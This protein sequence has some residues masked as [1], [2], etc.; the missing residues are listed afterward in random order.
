MLSC[1]YVERNGPYRNIVAYVS[2]P[3][4][5]T[6][7]VASMIYLISE[8]MGTYR[9]LNRGNVLRG[10]NDLSQHGPRH[11]QPATYS[12]P[13]TVQLQWKLSNEWTISLEKTET[14][15][16]SFLKTNTSKLPPAS[17]SVNKLDKVPNDRQHD[18]YTQSYA[19]LD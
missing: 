11:L 19:D 10:L 9:V 3:R 18:P 14:G 4:H 16:T 15:I 5:Y 2:G 13:T 7:Q 12:T 17:P 6:L 1:H 8:R